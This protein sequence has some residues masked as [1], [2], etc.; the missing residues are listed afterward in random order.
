MTE[1]SLAAALRACAAGLYPAEAAAELLI[2][3]PWPCRHDFRGRFI[4]TGTSITDGTTPMAVTD[5]AAATAALSAGQ[6]PCSGAERRLLRLAASLGDGIP[7]DLQDALTSLDDVRLE[8][9]TTAIRHAAG[10]RP[11]TRNRLEETGQSRSF[12][13]VR[14]SVVSTVD[15]DARHT[16]KSPHARRDGFRAHVAACPQTGIITDE[17]LTRASGE[18]NSDSAVAGEFLA[19][20]AGQ[21]DDP[22]PGGAPGTAGSGDR[23]GSGREPLAW[24]GDTAYGTGDLRDA[25][26]TAGDQAVIKPKPLQPAVPGGLPSMTSPSMSRPGPPPAQP[27]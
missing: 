15:P 4:R 16:R 6:L 2:A 8:L 17:K 22:G 3:T 7:V 5:W 19:A 12:H 14:R 20:A 25:I 21:D 11:A 26:G 1:P 18:D 24:Y 27:G 10:R 13:L 23:G 9:V